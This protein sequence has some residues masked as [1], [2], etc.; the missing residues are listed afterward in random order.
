M[1][2]TLDQPKPALNLDVGSDQAVTFQPFT[3]PSTNQRTLSEPH[4]PNTALPLALKPSQPTTLGA[5]ITTIQTLQTT[6]KTLTTLLARHGALLFRNLPIHSADDFSRFAHAFGYSPHEIIGIVVDRPLLAPNVAPANEAPPH[7]RIHSHNESPQVPHAPGYIF[8]HAH[9]AP[10]GEG[11]GGET[12]LSSSLELFR[13]VKEEMPE[14]VDAL[15]R[16]GVLSRVT[17]KVAPQYQG[18]STLRQAFG[19]HIEDGD[20]GETR[21][22]KIEAQLRRYGRGDFTSWEWGHDEEGQETLVVQ[23]RLLVVRMQSGTGLPGLFTGLASYWWNRKQ[24]KQEDQARRQAGE[25]VDG[26]SA[27]AE[28]GRSN[29]TTQLFGDGS[30]IPEEWLEGLFGIT[31]RIRVLHRWEEGDVLVLDNEIAQHGREPWVGE[32]GDRVVYAS[33]WDAEDV[34]GRYIYEGAQTEGWEGVVRAGED[35]VF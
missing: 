18:G 8:F 9:V 23:H 11:T 25:S 35:V 29:V 21:K 14:F 15:A 6:S 1:A 34:P 17:Y 22:R 33:L 24:Q 19:K 31:E 32:Q 4:P 28:Q 27:K 7:V 12:P 30:E 5:A 13:I 10:A 20:D 16:K 2:T 3:L 26:R